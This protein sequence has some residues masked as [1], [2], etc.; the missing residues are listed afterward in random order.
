[1]GSF[2]DM[3]GASFLEKVWKPNGGNT[4]DN[5]NRVLLTFYFTSISRIL[6]VF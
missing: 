6:E 3:L 1:M 2:D 5:L 4:H